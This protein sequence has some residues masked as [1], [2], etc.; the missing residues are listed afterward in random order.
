MISEWKTLVEH[1]IPENNRSVVFIN[2]TGSVFVGYFKTITRGEDKGV[3][4]V[5][6]REKNETNGM[7]GGYVHKW[8]TYHSKNHLEALK[9]IVLWDYLPTK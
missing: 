1:G 6:A 7:F 3:I 2:R 8:S 4:K 9:D 5:E